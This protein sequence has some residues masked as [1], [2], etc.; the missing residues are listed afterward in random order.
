MR[1]NLLFLLIS[2]LL[3]SAPA[4]AEVVSADNS[5]FQSRTVQTIAA[6]PEKVYVALG[7]IDKWWHPHHTWSLNS[8]NLHLSLQAG[9]CFCEKL[10]N[11]GSVQHMVVVYAAPGKELRLRGVLGPLQREAAVGSWVFLL[12]AKGPATEVVQTYSVGGYMQGGWTVVAPLNDAVMIKQLGRLK[13]YVE[14]G[15]PE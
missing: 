15:K 10:E 14:T 1:S 9:D 7:E 2:T 6:P 13:R 5:G 11:G 12:S 4:R 3:L 8:A